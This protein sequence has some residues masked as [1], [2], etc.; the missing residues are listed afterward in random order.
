MPDSKPSALLTRPNEDQRKWLEMGADEPGGKLPS[1]DASGIRIEETVID[2][3]LKA[4]WVEQ[5]MYNPLKPNS[6]VCRLTNSGR[7]AMS[8]DQVIRVD[9]TKWQRDDSLSA[10]EDKVASNS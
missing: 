6:K 8:R 5:W 1:V 9:F 3:C 2:A 4:G 10:V 7:D